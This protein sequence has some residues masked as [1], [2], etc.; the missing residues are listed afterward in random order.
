MAL[1]KTAVAQWLRFFQYNLSS[2]QALQA[3]CEPLARELSKTLGVAAAVA[4][5]AYT[6]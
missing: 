6:F 5:R 1:E 2:V 4:P 3:Q